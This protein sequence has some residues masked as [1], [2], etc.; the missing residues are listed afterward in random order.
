MSRLSRSFLSVDRSITSIHENERLQN[1]LEKIIEKLE[2]E[3]QESMQYDEQIEYLEK[4]KLNF[5]I[6]MNNEM[7]INKTESK[8]KQKIAVL[9]RK[10]ELE[11]TQLNE[12]CS[13]NRISRAEVNN[14]RRDAQHYKRTIQN[15]SKGIFDHESLVTFKHH[16]FT[17][18][19]EDENRF[20][21]Q[22][23]KIRSKSVVS[24]QSYGKRLSELNTVILGDL[25]KRNS[26]RKQMDDGMFS[27]ISKPG[28]AFD[29]SKLLKALL[30]GWN[31]KIR[32]RKKF[33][34]SYVK[35]MSKLE[36][37][38]DQMVQITGMGSTDEV[39]TAFIKSEDQ[40]YQVHAY[41][42]EMWAEIDTLEENAIRTTEAIRKYETSKENKQVKTAE[43]LENL[44]KKHEKFQ[45]RKE[46]KMAEVEKYKKT[47]QS[48][49]PF[50][51]SI[52]HSC[53]GTPVDLRH[54]KRIKIEDET[55][56][57]ERNIIPFI[58]Q[59]DEFL[60][61]L[62]VF[63]GSEENHSFPLDKLVPKMKGYKSKT[64][65]P[66]MKGIKD[67]IESRDL[68]LDQ[69]I[70]ESKTPIPPK[71]MRHRAKNIGESFRLEASPRKSIN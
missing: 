60:S 10:L 34:D 26:V 53:Q 21:K 3:K 55:A 71:I 64:P 50:L 70:E 14:I 52:I 7:S 24:H 17:R 69:E 57:N 5:K 4:E 43:L 19:Y 2:I 20:K 61:Y 11:M 22:L 44:I 31:E 16:E 40:Q 28:E 36:Y 23:E 42:N 32:E 13:Q 45:E 30:G 49:I 9:E 41:I 56:I 6:S 37:I 54:S 35:R 18:N 8:L 65:E 15:L 33:L 29:H 25:E 59:I 12:T 67:I 58:G 63:L 66:R 39:A 62:Y 1:E 68:Y 47:L 51:K 46:A 48:I 27:R 38:F